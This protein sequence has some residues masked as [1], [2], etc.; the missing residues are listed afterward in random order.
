MPTTP[1][2]LLP[3][4]VTA[5][6][7]RIGVPGPLKP[8][9]DTLRQLH[10]AHLHTIPFENLGIHLDEDMSLDAAALYDK[11]VVRRRGGF[12]YEL[13]GLFAVLLESLGYRVQR[14]SARTFTA[15]QGF[16]PPLD[17]LALRVADEAGDVWLADVGY[18]RHTE[19]P[20]AFGERAE[21]PDPG[22]RFRIAEYEDGELDVLREGE[23]QYRVDPRPLVLSDFTM[24]MWWHRTSPQ[25]HFTQSLICSRLT[26]DGGR[27]SLSG[28][29]LVTTDATGSRQEKELA[30]DDDVLAAYRE[31]FGIKLM[32]V[33]E[34]RGGRW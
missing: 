15:E 6:L 34:V 16:S 25:S 4:Q 30:S 28:R 19:F 24:A 31:L 20:L 26:S 2:R 14:I 9:A 29:K 10:S 12:C 32:R 33:P 8:D 22:G 5:Y 1:H 13:N 11:I 7:E 23:V 18:G 3:N 21:Q 27:V 17:H